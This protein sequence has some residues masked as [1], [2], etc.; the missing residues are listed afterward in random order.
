VTRASYYERNKV[1]Q[2]WREGGALLGVLG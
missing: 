1:T 2:G